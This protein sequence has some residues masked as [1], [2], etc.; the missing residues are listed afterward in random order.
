MESLA[1]DLLKE[2][3]DYLRPFSKGC[4]ETHSCLIF[5]GALEV[6]YAQ[7]LWQKKRLYFRGGAL[8]R[9][10]LK[11]ADRSRCILI[12]AKNTIAALLFRA[13]AADLPL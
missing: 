6:L 2:V 11:G 3:R 8:K 10:A 13:S 1:S 12:V 7:R 5:N 4:F 9:I